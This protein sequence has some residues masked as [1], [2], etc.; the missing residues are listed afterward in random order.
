MNRLTQFT[1]TTALCISVLLTGCFAV[2][3]APNAFAVVRAPDGGYPGGNTA[4]GINALLGLT[5]G[6]YNTAVGVNSLSSTSTG[7]FNTAIGSAALRFNTTSDSNAAVGSY[8]L[9]SNRFG[10]ATLQSVTVLCI[11]RPPATSTRPSVS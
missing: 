11:V 9:F 6:Q 3:L 10:T 5:S 7:T 8:A 4:E 1:K 2:C